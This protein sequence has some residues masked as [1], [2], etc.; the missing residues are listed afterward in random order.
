MISGVDLSIELQQAIERELFKATNKAE[1]IR[2]INAMLIRT[3]RNEMGKEHPDYGV[4][5]WK[6]LA[7]RVGCQQAMFLDYYAFFLTQGGAL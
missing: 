3:C 4:A 7:F 5:D 2:R 1:V 6:E